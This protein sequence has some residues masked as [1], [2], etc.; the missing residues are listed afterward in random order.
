MPI[1][2]RKTLKTGFILALSVVTQFIVMYLRYKLSAIV[3]PLGWDASWK[4]KKMPVEMVWQEPE[5]V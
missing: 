2:V 5:T 4:T 3:D 1:R